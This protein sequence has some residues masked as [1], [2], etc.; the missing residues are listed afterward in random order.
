[1]S[2][3]ELVVIFSPGIFAKVIHRVALTRAICIK[4]SP[5]GLAQ[6]QTNSHVRMHTPSPPNITAS[7]LPGPKL[8]KRYFYF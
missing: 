8:F 4:K 2:G 6:R 5:S 7:T 1:M 3:N